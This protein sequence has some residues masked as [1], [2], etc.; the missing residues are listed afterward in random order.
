VKP[1]NARLFALGAAAALG[2][3][4]TAPAPA[5]GPAP[6]AAPADTAPAAAAAPAR[7]A[8]PAPLE[9]R[10]IR[11]PQFTESTLPN[12]LRV[13]V[14]ENHRLPVTNVT[15][16]VESGTADDPRGRNGL[17]SLLT[18]VLDSGTT[19]R[20][21]RQIAET[22]ESAGGTL[23]AATDLDAMMI[24][25][26]VLSDQL[27]L[28]FD[29]VSDVALRP[30]FPADE[31][32]TSRRQVLSGLQVA[33]GNA[34]T[35]AQR[36]I[37]REIYGE[38][39]PYAMAPTPE[40]VRA[41]TRADLVQFHRRHF[42]P[43]NALLVVS[44]D[45]TPAQAQELARRHFGGWQG[46]EAPQPALTAPAMRDRMGIVLVHRPGS[47]QSSIRVGH[48]GITADNPDYY[49]LQVLNTILGGVSTSR[50]ERIIRGERAWTYVARSSFTRS[51]GTGTFVGNTEVRNPVTDSALVEM[52]GQFRRIRDEPVSQQ[53]LDAAK[54]F[55]VGSFPLRFETAA[56]TASQIA[57]VRL[58]GLPVESLQQYTQKV[59]AV[60][61]EEV[62]RVARQYLHP[63][64]ASIVV[65][66]D[67]AQVLKPL[68]AVGPVT[69]VDV[70]GRPLDRSALEVRASTDRFDASRLQPAT[71]TYAIMAGGNA[72]GTATTTLARDGA[73]WVSTQTVQAGPTSTRAE[74]RFTGDFTPI[75]GKTSMTAGAMSMETDL[76]MENGRVKG[77]AKLPAQ[78]GGEKAIDAEAVAGTRFPGTDP[79]IL[80]VADLAPGRTIAFPTFNAQSGSAAPV[81]FRV[82]G[83]EKV[84]VPAGTFDTWKVELSGPQPATVW[85]RKDAPHVT[86]KQA[87][88]AQPVTIE[89]QSM[90]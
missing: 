10:P 66:G 54:S 81:S 29:L 53:E 61:P 57:V 56:A 37:A 80:A 65:V 50:L 16:Y 11:F 32:E 64:R 62:Q 25:S 20:T 78:M 13:M 12:G 58:L 68:E 26:G 67:A 21:A 59:A 5:A 87:L 86:V 22:I 63:D 15:L 79:W 7:Q 90:Q 2:A 48:P 47:V 44:G 46:G 49:S 89:L 8:P 36:R 69:L 75:S 51:R 84:T 77:T 82:S 88:Q 55:L 9:A 71:L 18:D 38:G 34:G 17:A 31:L 3:C 60:T 23:D 19:R 45:V 43:R 76:R 1:F 14:V 70:E 74:V 42:T 30:T 33:L 83:E 52:L 35:I 40:A 6:A 85:V 41:I 24:S 72:V 27:P 4:S 28:A 39:H 73:A